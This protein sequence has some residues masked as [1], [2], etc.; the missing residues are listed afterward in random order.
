MNM[1][2]E[3]EEIPE[4]LRKMRKFTIL[5][6]PLLIDFGDKFAILSAYLIQK[7]FPENI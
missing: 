2:K 5:I 1:E 3:L 4:N 7:T 6:N